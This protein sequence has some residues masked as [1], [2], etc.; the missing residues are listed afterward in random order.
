MLFAW[1]QLKVVLSIIMINK[2]YT[3]DYHGAK[4]FHHHPCG[5]CGTGGTGGN[6]GKII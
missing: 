1:W 2:S 3:F 4:I 6:G 5:S